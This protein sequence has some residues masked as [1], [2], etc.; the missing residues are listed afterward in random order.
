MR[1]AF[2]GTGLLGSGFIHHLLATTGSVT[3]WNRTPARAE[4]VVAA[5]AQLA[6]TPADAARDAERIHLCLKDDAAVDAVLDALLPAMAP[7]AVLVDHTTTSADG[8]AA[9]GARLAAAGHGFLHAPVFMSPGMARVGK[10]IMLAAGPADVFARVDGALAAMT[11]DLWYV[12]DDLRKAAGLKLV[13]NA[14]LIAIT[15]AIADTLAVGRGLGLSSADVNEVLTRLNPGASIGIRGKRMATGD[16]TASFELAMARK[17]VGLML[18]AVG[19][20]PLATLRAI[21]ER[22]DKLIAAGHGADDLGV[23]ALDAVRTT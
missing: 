3:V 20:A 11:G 18:E 13:G 21:A 5:G 9:R 7:D 15:G 2:L 19:D 8:A 14:T 17:D 23:L 22:S 1:I 12:G 6:A 10:G 4:G 16:F